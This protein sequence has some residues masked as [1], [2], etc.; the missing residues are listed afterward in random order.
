MTPGHAG[1]FKFL[2]RAQI[3]QVYKT[4]CSKPMAYRD[5]DNVIKTCRRFSVKILVIS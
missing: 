1:I 3:R 2:R 4:E 5:V